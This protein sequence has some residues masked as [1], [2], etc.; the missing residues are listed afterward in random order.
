[1]NMMFIILFH[2]ALY[3]A[4]PVLAVLISGRKITW[5]GWLAFILLWPIAWLFVSEEL[6]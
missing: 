6:P 4:I 5:W 3:I 1:M 2:A